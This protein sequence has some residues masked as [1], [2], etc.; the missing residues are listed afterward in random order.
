MDSSQASQIAT[1]LNE[2]NQLTVQYDSERV[3][4]HASDYLFRLD[5]AG[6]VIA[7]AELRRVQWYQFELLHVTVADHHK[8]KGLARGLIAEAQSIAEQSGARILQSTIRDGNE[9]SEKLFAGSG[10]NSA[11]VFYNERSG[12]LIRVW[13]KVL[14]PP[15]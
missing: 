8:K 4:K 11:C 1:L 15:P 5:D 10:F 12:N 2:Q 9:A 3:L 7:C 14:V 6:R 13:Q